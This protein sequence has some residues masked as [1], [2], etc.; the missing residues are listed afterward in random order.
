MIQ[1]KQNLNL[2]INT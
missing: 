2:W 1:N